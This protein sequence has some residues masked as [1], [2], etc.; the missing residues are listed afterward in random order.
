MLAIISKVG[1][2]SCPD[3]CPIT[4]LAQTRQVSLRNGGNPR[5]WGVSSFWHW[6]CR[7]SARMNHQPPN[8]PWM[9]EIYQIILK[10]G[11]RKCRRRWWAWTWPTVMA[12]INHPSRHLAPLLMSSPKL[13]WK[14]REKH[15]PT[16]ARQPGLW[17]S[18]QLPLSQCPCHSAADA[19]PTVCACTPQLV[20]VSELVSL[21]AVY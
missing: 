9:S 4:R 2:L 1:Q 5:Q 8:S 12:R 6:N 17:A 20:P 14:E 19:H 16:P 10:W 11:M 7:N 3:S 21:A 13:R 18:M 15:S